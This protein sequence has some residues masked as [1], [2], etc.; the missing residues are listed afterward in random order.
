MSE[1]DNELKYLRKISSIICCASIILTTGLSTYAIEPA[2][3]DPKWDPN[4]EQ[5][6]FHM[7]STSGDSVDTIRSS[8]TYYRTVGLKIQRCY[9]GTNTPTGEYFTCKID[10]RTTYQANGKEY[11]TFGTDFETFA[12]KA[13]PSWLQEYL[14]AENGQLAGDYY[15]LVDCLMVVYENGVLQRGP[16]GNPIYYDTLEGILGAE[17]WRDPTGLYSHYNKFIHIKQTLKSLQKMKDAML[18]AAADGADGGGDNN[19]DEYDYQL[20]HDQTKPI[21][22]HEGNSSPDG[23]DIGTGIPTTEKLHN[24]YDA[25]SWYAETDVRMRV[26]FWDEYHKDVEYKFQWWDGHSYEMKTETWS[27]DEGEHSRSVPDYDRPVINEGDWKR[28]KVDFCSPFHSSKGDQPWQMIP[29]VGYEYLAN[30]LALDFSDAEVKNKT[31][32]NGAIR[33]SSNVTVTGQAMS[34]NNYVDAGA[35]GMPAK[36]WYSIPS[37]D[38]T[39]NAYW[40]GTDGAH[41]ILKGQLPK[42]DQFTGGG[43]ITVYPDNGKPYF[44]GETM[45]TCGGIEKCEEEHLGR[46]QDCRSSIEGVVNTRNDS[47]QITASNSGTHIYMK[48][49]EVHGVNF[50][51]ED[52]KVTDYS[53]YV[54]KKDSLSNSAGMKMGYGNFELLS[55]TDTGTDSGQQD[56]TIPPKVDNGDYETGFIVN[57]KRIIVNDGGQQSFSCDTEGEEYGL[58]G[59]L[60]P[61]HCIDKGNSRPGWVFIH[62]PIISLFNVISSSPNN[63]G[64]IPLSDQAVH[65]NL[66]LVSDQINL[67]KTSDGRDVAQMRLDNYYILD[68]I[69]T[70][71]LNKTGYGPSETT[72]PVANKYGEHEKYSKYDKYTL[73][74]WVKFP[75]AVEYDG[76]LYPK[77]YWILVKSPGSNMSNVAGSP[78]YKK[79]ANLTAGTKESDWYPTSDNHWRKMPFYIPSFAEEVGGPGR[80][81]KIKILVEAINVNGEFGGEHNG[82]EYEKGGPTSD[83]ILND[84]G[85]I[86]IDESQQVYSDPNKVLKDSYGDLVDSDKYITWV[87]KEQ[88]V[89]DNNDF[90]A[91]TVTISGEADGNTA[92]TES[93]AAEMEDLWEQNKNV[94]QDKW[95]DF[96]KGAHYCCIS[97]LQCQ[98]SG[99]IYGFTIVGSSDQD[100]FNPQHTNTFDTESVPFC[101]YKEE[102]TVGDQNRIGGKAMRYH[103]DGD[104]AR[105]ASGKLYWPHYNTLVLTKGKS[106]DLPGAGTVIK[107]SRFSFLL[108][109]IANLWDD[110]EDWGAKGL[111]G[112]YIKIV[113]TFRYYR[114]DVP[115]GDYS[116]GVFTEVPM[117]K[118]KVY[119]DS[120]TSPDKFIEYGSAADLADR[121]L[122]KVKLAHKQFEDSYYGPDQE[123]IA[124]VKNNSSAATNPQ[125]LKYGD[126]VRYTVEDYNSKYGVAGNTVTQQ[127][128]L[129]TEHYSYNL[130]H[131]TLNS[132]LRFLSGENEELLRNI[133]GNGNEWHSLRTLQDGS[134]N[135]KVPGVDNYRTEWEKRFRDSMQTWYGQYYV[136]NNLYIIDLT[137]HP[138]MKNKTL[139]QY[140]KEKGGITKDDPIFEDNTGYLVINFSILSYNNGEPHLQYGGKNVGETVRTPS[141]T[142][143]EEEGFEYVIPTPDVDTPVKIT[144]TI[145]LQDGDV[146]V[147][148]LSKSVSNKYTAAIFNIN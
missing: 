25:T 83:I 22:Y 27:D 5:N 71:H 105:D 72:D 60:V 130:S 44:I 84:D 89:Q 28:G 65:D 33:Y 122:Q 111:K 100:T 112:D 54:K 7:D 126:W 99:I 55:G 117:D 43:T 23:Y 88:N 76:K 80:D 124:N 103:S 85:T 134:D 62:T 3:S 17:G 95:A 2:S 77:N 29:I 110:T 10:S 67:G 49:D 116:H 86:T 34:T 36:D 146:A 63:K 61:A 42:V 96:P 8:D 119:Y 13:S 115:N 109:T 147:V 4:Q 79:Q 20:T 108:K 18:P 142:M 127:E 37:T 12:E 35:P 133:K 45:E 137:K 90:D 68:F 31:F 118:L 47:L 59:G 75:F 56:T 40:H 6:Q 58:G 78:G 46:R 53:Q 41:I 74:K 121:N 91:H 32:E 50:L 39:V 123:F 132:G 70:D 92:T 104:I 102:K 135:G 64:R 51:K 48:N 114:E 14:A 148:D 9:P 16:D 87:L 69:Q 66:Q 138:E 129:N 52:E 30:T 113:P 26:K 128:Y 140:A 15:V 131:I 94:A 106:K 98:T 38:D 143:W 82:P 97:E 1:R 57:Y 11:N 93:E 120:P 81:A 125:H 21:E 101:P 136:P 141:K 139:E 24:E 73:N 144:D 107:G 145:E 19:L